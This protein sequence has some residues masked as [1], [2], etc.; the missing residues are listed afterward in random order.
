MA[1]K[2]TIF[3]AKLNIVDVDRNYYQDHELTIAQHPSEN[4]ARMM[5][6]LLAF[7]M[8][9]SET[10]CFSKALS[11]DDDEAELWDKS[12][13]GEINLWVAFGQSDEKWLRK[14]CGRAKQVLL[15]TYGGKSVPIWWQ[16]NQQ[17]LARYTNLTI[18]NIP[19]PSVQELAEL[20]QRNMNI[21]CN[22]TDGEIW[23]STDSASVTINPEILKAE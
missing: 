19:E 9:A 5:V 15:I 3:K 23:L 16:Q 2:A 17:A 11:S 14:A 6:R 21:Q 22:I 13:S 20:A 1:L 4:N 8:R 7:M 12:L 18:I 10:L